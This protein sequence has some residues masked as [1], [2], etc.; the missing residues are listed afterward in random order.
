[1]NKLEDIVK[2]IGFSGLLLMI[3]L[4]VCIFATIGGF[5]YQQPTS[6][7]VEKFDW[8]DPSCLWYTCRVDGSPKLFWERY[9]AVEIS[10]SQGFLYRSAVAIGPDGTI[11]TSDGFRVQ[12]LRWRFTT[13][14]NLPELP[15]TE[16]SA[17]AVGPDD[18]I[19]VTDGFWVEQLRRPFISWEELP[20]TTLENISTVAVGSDDTIAITDGFGVQQLS[21]PFISW[22]DLPETTLD[23]ISAVA[24]GPDDIIVATDGFRVQ[25]L[26]QP[27]TTWKD[28]PETTLD[29]ISAVAIGPDDI[30]V[31]TDGF[32]V[33]QL[34]QPFTTW[35]DL[36]ELEL[37]PD[38]GN[39]VAVGVR[40]DGTIVITQSDSTV[41]MWMP[42]TPALWSWILLMFTSLNLFLC[43]RVFPPAWRRVNESSPLLLETDKPTEHPDQATDAL[44]RV[45][46]R[47]SR[48][49]SNPDASAP[50]TFALTGKWGSGKSSLMKLVQKNLNDIGYPCVWFNAW[51]HQ[52]ET[53]LFAALMESIRR[54]AVPRSL[55]N[56]GSFLEFFIALFWRRLLNYPILFILYVV[57][58]LGG[59]AWLLFEILPDLF[60]WGLDPT[61]W[62]ASEWWKPISFIVPPWVW[63][64]RWNPLKVFGVKPASL[65]RESTTRIRFPRFRDQLSFRHRFGRAFGEVCEA[66]RDRRLVILIDDL[67]RCKLEQVVVILE[68]MN[69]LT[70]NGACFVLLG[71]DE[72]HVKNAIGLHYRDIA[73]E[74]AKETGED[75]VSEFDKYKARQSYAEDYLQKLINLNVKIP[76]FDSKDL[77]KLRLADL[78]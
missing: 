71:I 54:D 28:L 14:E 69:F 56:K 44:N 2:E 57:L 68:A 30:I 21:R 8:L 63:T 72:S 74:K 45:A 19:A 36:P 26:M 7:D 77:S 53:N 46:N 78:S 75:S 48:F 43:V 42:I 66:F 24:I 58:I 23:N 73:E 50:V 37:A 20:E 35:E 59:L 39:T 15:I 31:A 67:D 22:E 17:I 41:H 52:N 3:A 18:T 40:P 5:R 51:H 10:N 32:R 34:M 6:N 76:V 47:I 38:L 25:R 9:A 61:K 62:P 1:M 4:I 29:K 60:Q 49:V 13:R 55:L 65:V 27:F 11:V 64:T 70:S 33:Q 12:R 16:L